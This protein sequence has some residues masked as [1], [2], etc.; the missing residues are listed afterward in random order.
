MIVVFVVIVEVL[1]TI[2]VSLPV[3]AIVILSVSCLVA[4][5]PVSLA[6]MV[7]NVATMITSEG[8]GTRKIVVVIGETTVTKVNVPRLVTSM[9]PLIVFFGSFPRNSV[10]EGGQGGD[11][12]HSSER[13][14]LQW[15]T[16][17]VQ[18]LLFEILCCDLINPE[19]S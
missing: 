18:Y 12:H 17:E 4:T 2:S 5:M 3:L 15:E 8:M 13:E 19:T 1:I 16:S 9:F 7:L 14:L 10:T 11:T 6:A